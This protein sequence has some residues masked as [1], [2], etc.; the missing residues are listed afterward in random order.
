MSHDITATQMAEFKFLYIPST[1]RGAEGTTVAQTESKQ[2]LQGK[3]ISIHFTNTFV[4]RANRTA[5]G[6][7]IHRVNCQTDTGFVFKEFAQSIPP[8]YLN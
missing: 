2:L 3:R 4:L 6:S 1:N 7:A 8:Y 5:P